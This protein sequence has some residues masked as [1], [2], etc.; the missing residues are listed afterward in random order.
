MGIAQKVR[1]RRAPTELWKG[2]QFKALLKKARARAPQHHKIVEG[3]AIQSL[4][5]KSARAR[6][7]PTESWKGIRYK[8]LLKKV[9]ARRA[10]TESWKG[11][12]F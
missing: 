7:A 4:A 11:I 5:Q 1:A 6:R 3:Y 10:P 8:A 9:R 2:L 12:R